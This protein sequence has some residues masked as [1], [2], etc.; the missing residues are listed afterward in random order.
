MSWQTNLWIFAGLKM[1]LHASGIRHR[2]GNKK[3]VGNLAYLSALSSFLSTS[4]CKVA[5]NRV[6]ALL[7]SEKFDNVS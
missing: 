4:N 5:S 2:L 7:T 3:N 6:L 1:I